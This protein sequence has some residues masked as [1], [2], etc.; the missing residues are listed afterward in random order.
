MIKQEEEFR[1]CHRHQVLVIVFL[2]HLGS[3]LPSFLITAQKL[4]MVLQETTITQYIC[5]QFLHLRALAG[6][7]NRNQ[8]IYLL[9]SLFKK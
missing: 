1:L 7:G 9:V 2:S 3:V 5:S 4:L 6:M 8:A